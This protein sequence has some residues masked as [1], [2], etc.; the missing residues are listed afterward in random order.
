MSYIKRFKTQTRN[1]IFILIGAT[2]GYF[3]GCYF[4]WR[5]IITLP[6]QYTVQFISGSLTYIFLVPFIAKWFE[7]LKK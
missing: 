5:E 2:I 3:I 4:G 1:Y 6:S 7:S